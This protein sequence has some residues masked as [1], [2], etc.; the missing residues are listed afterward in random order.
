MKRLTAFIV[1]L[2]CVFS[3]AGCSAQK[4]YAIR[5]T[6]PAGNGGEFV[7]SEEE[8]SSR[9]TR[10]EIQ[11]IDMP[12]DAQFVLTAVGKTQENAFECTNFP[13]GEPML[14]ELEKETWYKI[15]IAMENTTE[16]DI[17]VVLHIKNAK[18][19]IE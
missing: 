9:K 6:V 19:R 1:T 15:G 3:L 13:K 16:E 17:T 2:V 4:E 5:I 11:S 10:L 7:Y 8:I 14:I 12:E 18:V